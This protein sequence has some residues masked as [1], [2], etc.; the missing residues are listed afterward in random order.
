MAGC[1]SSTALR[2]PCTAFGL[3]TASRFPPAYCRGRAQAEARRGAAAAWTIQASGS[4]Y[5]CPVPTGA[6]P[7]T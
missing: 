6:V 1:G 5:E 2:P 3:L 4:S 7:I